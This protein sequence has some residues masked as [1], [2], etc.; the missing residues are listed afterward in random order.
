MKSPSE[1]I[2]NPLSRIGLP[3]Q[4]I[5]IA[6]VALLFRLIYFVQLRDNSPVY[7]LLIHD[8]ALFDELARQVVNHGVVLEQPFYVSPLY[9]YF[10]ALVY[11][12]FGHSFDAVRFI[13]F[14]LGTGTAV[15]TFLIARR[16][17]GK[18]IAFVAGLLTAIYAPLIFIEGNLLGTSVVTF[19]LVSGFFCL[20]SIRPNWQGHIL[21][22]LSGLLLALAITG[23]PNLILLVPVPL[24]YLLIK[25][26]EYSR[27]ILTFAV[28]FLVGISIPLLLTGF[29]NKAAGG[30]F[31][32]LTTHGGINFYIGNN[33][34]ATGVWMAPK[35]M[36]ASVSAINLE[37]S[38]AYAEH[39]LGRE[40]SNAD[41]SHF[42]YQQAFNFILKH[43]IHW[44]RLMLKKFML[45]W[46]A[47]ETPLNFNYYFHQQFSGLLKIP[48]FNLLLYM[49]FAIFGLILLARDWKKYWL[50]YAVIG[51]TCL[52]VILFFMADRY[53][54]VV[55][56]F[57]ITMTAAGVIFGIHTITQ[58]GS[59]RWIYGGVL[60]V[61]FGLEIGFAQRKA[62]HINYYD[63]YYNLSLA[64]FINQNYPDAIQWGQKAIEA[65]PGYVNAYYN[66]GVTYLKLKQQ[67]QAQRAFEAV[68]QL[69][70]TDAGAQRNLGG[71]LLMKGQYYQALKHLEIS[72][73]F[74][75]GNITTL[76]NVGLAY[77]YLHSYRH[78]IDIWWRVLQ[79]DP[80]NQQAR[81]NI[82][83]AQASLGELYLP[84][85]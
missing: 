70:S 67:N 81:R 26:T 75:P 2:S 66:L 31:T 51:L 52:S 77:Y 64:N 9:I 69:D 37:Q 24:I 22:L 34:R 76:M 33:A 59:Q 68:V 72:L 27:R 44:I 35:G 36:N 28:F 71:L 6:A 39:A 55:M 84:D 50:L 5:I 54:L 65:N 11:K 15:F 80:K 8:S 61:L 20:I 12:V 25:R 32:L 78:A 19:L 48:L 47:Y 3:L 53:R 13:Q 79:A 10:L 7:Q 83:A 1:K 82:Q 41:V 43:P 42:W 58:K 16:I 57:L 45:F 85:S 17:F 4:I 30:Q 21:A 73:R 49:P 56:P 46:S 74:E 63:D 40:L 23:R 38:R 62:A 14:A 18:T 60:I 29:H